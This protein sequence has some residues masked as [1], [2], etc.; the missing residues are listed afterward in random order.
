V[1]RPSRHD[2]TPY[3]GVNVLLLWRAATE[4]GYAA[5]HWMTYRQAQELGG[6]VRQG[7]RGALVVYANTIKKTET[8]ER[9]GEEAEVE[10]PFLKGY[11]V[12]N[13]EQID[14]LP[15]RY[16][17]GPIGRRARRPAGRL[18]RRHRRGRPPR[19]RPGVLRRRLRSRPDAAVRDLPRPGELLRDAG[20]R[21]CP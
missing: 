17:A 6:Q 2:G 1:S 20:A 15:D 3:R 13:A 11:T 9:T 4:N 21:M 19:R 7:E 14:G 8:D 5:P 12:F 10:I 18:F 16:R